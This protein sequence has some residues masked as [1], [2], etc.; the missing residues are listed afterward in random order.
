MGG[1]KM[2]SVSLLV[3][4]CVGI[5]LYLVYRYQNGQPT[6]L[7]NKNVVETQEVDPADLPNQQLLWA[8]YDTI[9]T[10]KFLETTGKHAAGE[11]HGRANVT[12]T[13]GGGFLT[14]EQAPDNYVE[15]PSSI[16]WNMADGV[17]WTIALWMQIRSIGNGS[18]DARRRFLSVSRVNV[19]K[20]DGTVGPMAEAFYMTAAYTSTQGYRVYPFDGRG[21]K[22]GTLGVSFNP[23]DPPF[24]LTIVRDGKTRLSRPGTIS[25][26]NGCLLPLQERHV[27]HL[28]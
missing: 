1:M 27:R 26:R 18:T 3:I 14:S 9:D 28:L 12:P 23:N 19:D 22:S 7:G 8:R 2:S 15:L 4:I 10:N 6:Y 13:W 17:Y 20:Q 25:R 21:I 16:F 5:A 11:Q 24:M